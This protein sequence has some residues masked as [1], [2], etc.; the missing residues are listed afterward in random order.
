M[1]SIS[2]VKLPNNT[3]YDIR[4]LG[5]PYAQLD[6]TSTSTAMTVQIN[7]VTSLYDGLAIIVKNGRVTSATNCTLNVNSLGAK[8]IYYSTAAA[9]RVTTHF[10]SAYTWLF[11]YDS[12]RVSGGCWVAYWGYYSDSNT[13]PAAYC[14][15]AANTAAKV[16]TFTNYNLLANSYFTLLISTTNSV[17][18]AITLN[19]NGKGAK[20]IYING[21]ASSASNHTMPA[22]T[23]LVFYDGTNYHVRTDGRIPNYNPI[24][25][26]RIDEITTATSVGSDIVFS[27]IVVSTW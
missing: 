6:S 13:V 19:V 20:P 16:A 10:N 14:T 5:L 8:P 12:T 11:I 24:T 9:S 7:N 15:T 22:G 21:S 1:A 3:S 2:Q 27:P 26:A 4:A 18:G 25:N 17:A 23:Y